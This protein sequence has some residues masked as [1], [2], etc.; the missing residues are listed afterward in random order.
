[1]KDVT[2]RQK[3]HFFF[4][5]LRACLHG[6]GDPGLVGLVSFVFMPPRIQIPREIRQY[7]KNSTDGTRAWKPCNVNGI[8]LLPG[9]V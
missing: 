6:V 4:V 2:T 8:R 3:I 7:L 5:G 9:L 1:M